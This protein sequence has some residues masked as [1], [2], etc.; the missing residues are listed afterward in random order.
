MLKKRSIMVAGHAT[1]VSLE[2]E[3][4]DVLRDLA[5]ARGLSVNQLVADIDLGRDGN[6]SSAIRV[7]VLQQ[8][9]GQR[10]AP[11]GSDAGGH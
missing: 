4:W 11:G 1:S 6:L 7:F 10:K 5:E 2:Q 8:V 9:S 3:F